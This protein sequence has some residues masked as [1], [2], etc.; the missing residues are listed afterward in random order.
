MSCFSRTGNRSHPK[1]KP[2]LLIQ[3]DSTWHMLRLI[4]PTAIKQALSINT[5]MLH[6]LPN[7]RVLWSLLLFSRKLLLICL[8]NLVPVHDNCG[9]LANP[10][11]KATRKWSSEPNTRPN[12]MPKI[13]MKL[14]KCPG[15]QR[16][17]SS[18]RVLLCH[19]SPDSFRPLY[20]FAFLRYRDGIITVT[21]T[22]TGELKSLSN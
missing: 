15:L 18:H 22:T 1:L 2:P 6:L 12:P 11:R 9:S 10:P 21:P 4:T 13:P 8:A 16:G 14:R 3:N 17:F 5:W 19:N 7:T 20:K